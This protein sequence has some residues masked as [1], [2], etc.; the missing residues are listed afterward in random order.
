MKSIRFKHCFILTVVL[1]AMVA[2][3]GAA[4]AQVRVGGSSLTFNGQIIKGHA[5][6]GPCPVDLKFGW[7]LISTAPTNVTYTFV[8]SDG[9][10]TGQHNV[11]IP[12]ANKSVPVYDDW[13]L[14][15][16][17]PN[18]SNFQGWIELTIEAPN[19]VTQQTKFTLH[20]Q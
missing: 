1:V 20:C 4:L 9:G 18:F 17:K 12:R 15:A 16:N 19:A 14:G 6:T 3:A 5:Y 11:R 2:L 8:R 13:K 10:R 7:G